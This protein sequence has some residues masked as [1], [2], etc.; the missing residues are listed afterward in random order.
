MSEDDYS[1]IDCI[2]INSEKELAA[3]FETF[4]KLLFDTSG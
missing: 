1:D 4:N 2:Q 3:E